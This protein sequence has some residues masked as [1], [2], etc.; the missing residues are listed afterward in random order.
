LCAHFSMLLRSGMPVT[1]CMELITP[2]LE[3][4][5][6]KRILEEAR[7]LMDAGYGLA[8]SLE[9]AQKSAFS[10]AF[11]EMVRAGEKSGTLERSFQKLGEYYEKRHRI[12]Q[13]LSAAM[14]YPMVVLATAVAVAAVVMGKVLPSILTVFEEME[15][16]LPLS[17]KLLMAVS[18]FCQNHLLHGLACFLAMTVAVLCWKRTKQ[19]REIW[20]GFQLKIPIWGKLRLYGAAGHFAN[21]VSAMIGAGMTLPHALDITARTLENDMLA[22]ETF[23]IAGK[24]E[25]GQSLGECMRE[26][27]KY[28]AILNEVCAIG[29]KSGELEA[30][31]SSIGDYFDNRVDDMSKKAAA[32]LEPAILLV[33][34]CLTGF[35][36]ISIYLPLFTMYSLM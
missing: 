19:G 23:R 3:N 8:D 10:Q 14:T 13:K 11:L 35:L 16:E 33:L 17:T 15:G 25:E 34:A 9:Y 30:M 6:I 24:L 21:T 4:R 2:Q 5:K 27:G 36:V 31:L 32:R 28:P 12:N 29:E 20:S 26:G 1:M 22:R 7:E 18:G